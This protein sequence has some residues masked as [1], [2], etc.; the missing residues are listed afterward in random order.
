MP[1][2]WQG[3]ASCRGE[4][5]RLRPQMRRRRS[6]APTTTVK[7]AGSSGLPQPAEA[8]AEVRAVQRLLPPPPAAPLMAEGGRGPPCW[9][10]SWMDPG[11]P[12]VL[13]GGRG[14]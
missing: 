11:K 1:H 6:S 9:E 3:E 8:R 7:A 12:T 10:R 4:K 2:L 13:R 5:E 14:A